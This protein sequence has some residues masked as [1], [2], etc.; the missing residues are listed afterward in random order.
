MKLELTP[1]GKVLVDFDTEAEKVNFI[2]LMMST[3]SLKA[4]EVMQILNITRQTLC[5]YVKRGLIK[6]DTN[7]TGGQYR[8]NRDSVMALLN[9]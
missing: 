9:K 2:R 7:Y 1:E 4:G 3:E 6:I 5:N 8:Y